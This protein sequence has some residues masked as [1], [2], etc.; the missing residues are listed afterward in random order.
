MW[1][2]Y[3]DKEENQ[4]FLIYKLIQSGAVAKSYMRKGFLTYEEM[5]KNVPIY[6]EAVSHLPYDFA[7]APF[8]ISLYTRKLW[9]SFFISVEDVKRLYLCSNRGGVPTGNY[10]DPVLK[11]PARR[12]WRDQ[13]LPPSSKEGQIKRI[14]AFLLFCCFLV[15]FWGFV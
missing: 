14:F 1:K 2:L 4:I 7:T 5:L 11:G 12:I 3:T 10:Q 8:W 15:I 13:F 6:E 9:F